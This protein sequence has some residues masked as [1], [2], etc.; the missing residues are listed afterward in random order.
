MN[1]KTKM[2]IDMIIESQKQNAYAQQRENLKR[3]KRNNLFFAL[4][5]WSV[6]LIMASII[7][8]TAYLIFP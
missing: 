5:C 2:R 6:V 8:F 1:N 7:A 3:I 4:Q